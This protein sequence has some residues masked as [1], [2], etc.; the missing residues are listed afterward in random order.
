MNKPRSFSRKTNNLIASFRGL[1][2]DRSRAFWRKE[3]SMDAVMDR[4]IQRYQIIETRPEEAIRANWTSLVGEYNAKHAHPWR[5]DRS[6]RLYVMVSNPVVKQEMQF[7]KKMIL[8]R[9]TKIEGCEGIRELIFRA[10]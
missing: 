3:K 4:V 1:P 9:L 7:H 2:K 8:T 5:L 10:G 6:R